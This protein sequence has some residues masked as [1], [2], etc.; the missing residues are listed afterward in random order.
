MPT[1]LE[2]GATDAGGR[3][4][5]P[6]RGGSHAEAVVTEPAEDATGPLA[7]LSAGAAALAR[8]TDLDGALSV[9]VEVGAAAANAPIAALFSIDPDR[10]RL[11]LLLTIGMTDEQGAG[12]ETTVADDPTH[13]IHGAALDRTG[14]LGRTWAAEDGSSMTFA[15]LPLVVAG[16]GVEACVGVLSLGWEGGHDVDATEEALLVAVADLAAAAIASFRTSSMATERA[17]WFER[18]AHT[19]PLTG[20]SN[21]RTLG[22]VLELEV[23]RAQRQGSEVSIAMFDVDGFTELNQAAGSRAG[24][25]VLRQVASVLAETVRLVDTVAR[26]GG[27]EFVVVAPGS[28]GVAVARRVLDGIAGL[29]AIEGHPVSVSAGIARFPQDGADAESLL[30]AARAALERAGGKASI[31][32][33]AG[34][35]SA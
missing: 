10:S 19:D 14:T 16:G 12:F 24:D 3:A 29:E 20:L 33:A 1:R 26:T 13:P 27:D 15:D 8:S 21:A 35:P 7:V 22:R 30:V 32:E 28:A 9:I 23:A 34:E 17:E 4:G 6:R 25:Q 31:A 11:E 2:A 18:V 5:R